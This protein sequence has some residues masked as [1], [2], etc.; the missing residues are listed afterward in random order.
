MLQAGKA[1]KQLDLAL[2]HGVKKTSA[3]GCNKRKRLHALISPLNGEVKPGVF[4]HDPS[5]PAALQHICQVK[6]STP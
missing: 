6:S 4:A 2:I 1:G 5:L 3:A